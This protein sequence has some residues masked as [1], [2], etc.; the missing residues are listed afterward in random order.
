MQH[1]F[2][3]LRNDEFVLFYID[4]KNSQ[5]FTHLLKIQDLS[6][7]K[8]E[9]M[10]IDPTGTKTDARFLEKVQHLEQLKRNSNE[11]IYNQ[12]V[13]VFIEDLIANAGYSSLKISCLARSALKAHPNPVQL[14]ETVCNIDLSYIRH[15]DKERFENIEEMRQ[16]VA[17]FV[18][19][20]KAFIVGLLG[21]LITAEDARASTSRV[22]S[23]GN[24]GIFPAVDTALTSTVAAENTTL[25]NPF[26][27]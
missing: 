3:I 22:L 11:I 6:T 19:T 5:G 8:T 21:I 9:G 20:L 23:V 1:T 26:N 24:F 2:E 7:G 14:H 15:E 16:A 4:E 25:L 17:S 13:A 18:A 12:A 10:W 27:S